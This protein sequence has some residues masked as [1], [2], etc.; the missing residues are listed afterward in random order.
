ML[1]FNYGMDNPVKKVLLLGATGMLGSAVYGVLNKKYDLVIGIRN[2]EKAALLKK[3]FGEA[4]R[5]KIVP[6]D[7]ALM[8]LK[9]TPPKRDSRANTWRSSCIKSA[10]WI[11]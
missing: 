4:D 5:A 6:F 9:N 3:R 1:Y 10:R 2:L 11:V 7:A 8:I